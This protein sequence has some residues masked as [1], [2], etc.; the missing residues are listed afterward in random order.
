[1]DKAAIHKLI[2]RAEADT[3][4]GPKLKRNGIHGGPRMTPYWPYK[5][6]GVIIYGEL[7][8]LKKLPGHV[9]L[10]PLSVLAQVCPIKREIIKE[11]LQEAVEIGMFVA[12]EYYA[13]A[14]I[15]TVAKTPWELNLLDGDDNV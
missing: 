14:A 15:I 2:A 8:G 7:P 12:V 5:L 13:N 9:I 6:A 11:Y 3:E 4:A 10:A 1:M